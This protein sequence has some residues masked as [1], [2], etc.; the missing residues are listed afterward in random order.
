MV[1]SPAT[2]LRVASSGWEDIRTAVHDTLYGTYTARPLA[3]SVWR[4]IMKSI[5]IS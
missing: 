3:N 5:L 2:P 1:P 4:K